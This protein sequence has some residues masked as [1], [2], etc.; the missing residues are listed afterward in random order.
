MSREEVMAWLETLPEG[1]G[2]FIDDGGL[3]LRCAEETEAYL[4]VGG[5]MDDEEGA[6]ICSVCGEAFPPRTLENRWRED[7]DIPEGGVEDILTSIKTQDKTIEALKELLQVIHDVA[8]D[9]LLTSAITPQ[10]KLRAIAESVNIALGKK[11]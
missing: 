3:T 2:V 10:D 4:E 9:K 1:S 5:S 6:D 11:E 8:T 7:Q